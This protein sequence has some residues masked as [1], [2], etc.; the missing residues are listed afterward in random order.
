MLLPELQRLA[1]SMGITGTGRMRKSQLI[2]RIAAVEQQ[3]GGA[4]AGASAGGHLGREPEAVNDNSVQR[5]VPAGAGASRPVKQDAMEYDTTPQPGLGSGTP[6]G[7][8][9]DVVPAATAGTL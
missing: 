2:E 8:I 1:Q 7:G 5:G 4:A 9:G 3:R 6:A